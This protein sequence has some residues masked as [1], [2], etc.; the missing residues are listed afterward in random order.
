MWSDQY[1]S[2]SAGSLAPLEV[3]TKGKP[4]QKTSPVD[5]AVLTTNKSK[6]SKGSVSIQ[7]ASSAESKCKARSISGKSKDDDKSLPKA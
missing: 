7:S 4:L 6:M 1:G 5:P 3:Y 2:V